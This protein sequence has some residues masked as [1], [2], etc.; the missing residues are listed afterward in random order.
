M[1]S[2]V[3]LWN[4]SY[5]FKMLRIIRE[6]YF[7]AN[8]VRYLIYAGLNTIEYYLIFLDRLLFLGFLSILYI[9]YV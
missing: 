8:L 3:I 2:S 6:Y 9:L 5:N 1:L 7:V 4:W